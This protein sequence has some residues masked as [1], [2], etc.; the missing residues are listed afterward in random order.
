[1]SELKT[2]PLKKNRIDGAGTL[3][4]LTAC[5]NEI[6]RN[7][8][9]FGQDLYQIWCL[10]CTVMTDFVDG[11]YKKTPTPVKLTLRSFLSFTI[12]PMTVDRELHELVREFEQ[13]GLQSLFS[14]PPTPAPREEIPP[15]PTQPMQT[16]STRKKFKPEV[17][18]K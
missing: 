11:F 10:Q 14:H 3:T 7:L 15:T 1:M 2:R 12:E 9:L 18:S 16:R 4:A 8:A 5:N 6:L 13:G 17:H